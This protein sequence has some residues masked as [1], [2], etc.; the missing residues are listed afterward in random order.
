MFLSIF[1]IYCRELAKTK[2]IILRKEVLMAHSAK[3]S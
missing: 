1:C 3:V 2:E